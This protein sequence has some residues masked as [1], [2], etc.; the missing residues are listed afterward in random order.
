[1]LHVASHDGVPKAIT[2]KSLDPRTSKVGD[3]GSFLVRSDRRR[4][5]FV[6]GSWVRHFHGS[7]HGEYSVAVVTEQIA[8]QGQPSVV[9]LPSIHLKVRVSGWQSTPQWAYLHP[10]SHPNERT[11]TLLVRGSDP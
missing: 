3:E 11:R 4:Q 6:L 1:M 7:Q 2:G 10:R 8:S 9:R 5:T